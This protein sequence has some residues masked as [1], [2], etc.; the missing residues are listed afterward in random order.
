MP[1]NFWHPQ[2]QA[3]IVYFIRLGSIIQQSITHNR[4]E[5]FIVHEITEEEKI[6][7]LTNY[8]LPVVPEDEVS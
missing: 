1:S 6:V 7:R 8:E 4:Y 5:D 2:I 3:R